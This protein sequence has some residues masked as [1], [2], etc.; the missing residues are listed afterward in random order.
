MRVFLGIPLTEDVIEELSRKMHWIKKREFFKGNYV[1]PTKMHI[2]LEFLGEKSEEDI[3]KI[4]NDIEKEIN[5]NNAQ[6]FNI[7]INKIGFFPTITAPRVGWF[8][9]ENVKKLY[10]LRLKIKNSVGH[11]KNFNPHITFI[12]IKQVLVPDFIRKIR[13]SVDAFQQVKSF[14]LYKSSFTPKGHIYE[15]IHEFKLK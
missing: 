1:E 10:E 5:S 3:K 6:K 15:K 7:Q 4:I 13:I 9:F 12:R 2:T 11:T 14:I 8:G